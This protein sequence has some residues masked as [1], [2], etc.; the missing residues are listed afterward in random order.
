MDF[1]ADEMDRLRVRCDGGADAILRADFGLWRR[2]VT[3]IL[4][5]AATALRRPALA[6]IARATAARAAVAIIAAGWAVIASGKGF[7]FALGGVAGGA[8]PCGS[9]CETGEEAAHWIG[10]RITH[11]AHSKDRI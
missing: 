2:A 1:L 7:G 8:R 11:D 4:V 9:Q 3:T 6:A 5:V 10:I